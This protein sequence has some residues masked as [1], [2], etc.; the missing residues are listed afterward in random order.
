MMAQWRDRGQGKAHC[1]GCIY[2]REGLYEF[3]SRHTVIPA[4]AAM[5]LQKKIPSDPIKLTHLKSSSYKDTSLVN[6]LVELMNSWVKAQWKI[7][8]DNRKDMNTKQVQFLTGSENSKKYG[9]VSSQR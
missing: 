1:T 4:I 5:Q 9:C 8:L 2:A 3:I 6:G 7:N